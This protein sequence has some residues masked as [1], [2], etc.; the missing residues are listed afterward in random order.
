[1]YFED[2][3]KVSKQSELYTSIIKVG[4]EI[5]NTRFSC[6]ENKTLGNEIQCKGR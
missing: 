3:K 2:L 5:Y 4:T 6:V 1:M